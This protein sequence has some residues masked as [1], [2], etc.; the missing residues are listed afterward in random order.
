[1]GSRSRGDPV[2]WES[3]ATEDE[4]SARAAAIL[5]DA[6]STDPR[7]V[8]GL[9]TG[10]S[11]IGM[12]ARVVERCT[13]ETHCF[14][15]V[16]T[17]NLDEYVG[18]GRDHPSSYHAYMRHHL[19]DHVDVG[20][21][22]VHI[23]DGMASDLDLECRRYEEAIAE[24]GGLGLTFLGLG[25]NGHIG[26]N[27]PG[28]PFDAPTRVVELTPSTRQANADCF[29]GGEVPTHAITMGIGTILRS[30]AIVLLVSGSGKERAV[31]RL[32]SGS[33]EESFPAAALHRH[34][35]VLV[36]A[37]GGAGAM[38]SGDGDPDRTAGQPAPP[39]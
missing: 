22:N 15:E 11:P 33:L 27:E 26:F 20:P 23:P 9:P 29:S 1:M 18:V 13:R 6:I 10:R 34:P 31:E 35:N 19:F 17:F 5:L 25:R 14:H 30:R 36:L 12:Y 21:A 7:I 16:R 39:R 3:F 4:L 24:S 8:L 32:R 2:R 28:S 38:L 37:S